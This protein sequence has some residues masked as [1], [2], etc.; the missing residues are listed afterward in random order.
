MRPFRFRLDPVLDQ[1]RRRERE[2]QV[3][4]ARLESERA[5]AE[6]RLRAIQR[7]FDDVRA[8]L[9]QA[10]GGARHALAAAPAT[11]AQASGLV[12]ARA[13]SFD[14]LHLTRRAQAAAIEMAGILR[15]QEVA[16]AELLRAASAR[17]AVT[18][19]R[20]RALELH[21]RELQRR[22]AAELDELVVMR[23]GRESDGS[24]GS[25]IGVA[26]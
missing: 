8:E 4:V 2:A 18:L 26:S 1:R 23:H 19:L 21:R 7:E 5:A 20:E 13:L 16:R 10:L 17:K 9:R 24:A 11:T 15:R 14:S 12:T 3:G 6:S 22:E 25:T